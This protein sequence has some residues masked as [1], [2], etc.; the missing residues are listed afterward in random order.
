MMHD[1]QSKM[2]RLGL[3]LLCASVAV[4]SMPALTDASTNQTVPAACTS[5]CVTPYGTVLGVAPGKVD[6]YSNCSADCVITESNV[7]AGTYTGIKWQCVEF[8]RRWLLA[9]KGLVYGDVDVAADIWN[10]ITYLTRVTDQKKFLLDAYLNGSTRAP[11]VGD[12]LIYSREYEN[13]GHVAVITAVNLA[14]QSV[15]VTE[16]NFTNAVW[17][18]NYSRELE[19]IRKKGRYWIPNACLLGWKSVWQ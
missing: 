5:H 18:G 19:M 6:A 15:K 1:S 3:L 2:I 13:T 17:P 8:A 14:S 4:H 12:L 7:Q 11:R 16:Q 9:N 10:H